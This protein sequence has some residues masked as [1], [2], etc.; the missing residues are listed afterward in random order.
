MTFAEERA[1]AQ[2]EY[3]ADLQTTQERYWPD[4]ERRDASSP[5][6][7]MRLKERQ[8]AY[9]EGWRIGHTMGTEV[10]LQSQVVR[11]LYNALKFSDEKFQMKS[12]ALEAFE[13]AVREG[14]E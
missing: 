12:D 1:A 7:I 2:R 14:G 3:L 8:H 10:A 4:A 11:D 13:Q 9:R 5:D 6:G